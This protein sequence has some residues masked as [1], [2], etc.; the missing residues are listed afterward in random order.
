MPWLM[1]GAAIHPLF[2]LS[3]TVTWKG[4]LRSTTHAAGQCKLSICLFS[5]DALRRH[6]GTMVD[7]KVGYKLNGVVLIDAEWPHKFTCVVCYILR[8]HQ[9]IMINVEG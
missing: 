5:S 1:P 9:D 4:H 3:Y 8:R 2:I 6:C 7:A